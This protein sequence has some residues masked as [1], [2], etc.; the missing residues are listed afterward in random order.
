[1]NRIMDW[2]G[3]VF[4]VAN[5]GVASEIPLP[6][7]T[8]HGEVVKWNGMAFGSNDSAQVVARLGSNVVDRCSLASG[9]YPSTNYRLTIPMSESPQS[10]KAQPG[11]TVTFEVYYDGTVHA[12]ID[13]AQ[14][15]VVGAPATFAVCN[16]VVGTDS[17]A[18]GLPD[19]YEA[20]LEPY[21][22][23]KG[24][25][26]DEITSSDDFD[27]DGFSNLQEFLAGTV[28][29]MGEDFPSI[30]K[31][32]PLPAGWFAFTFMTAPGR[33]YTVQGADPHEMLEWSA[34][35]FSRVA[36]RTPDE[37]FLSTQDDGVVTLY[38]C[39]TNQA[40]L[41]QLQID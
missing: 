5:V 29:V 37:T 30:Q 28:P 7:F 36:D 33:T 27:G 38:L 35:I 15:P 19:E 31:W 22:L 2:I 18:N 41:Y 13:D 32:T 9:L 40:Q 26:L 8:Y 14:L 39:P 4:L 25:A 24:R 11:D 10:G 12:V 21:Y 20:L 34:E 17:N 3:L 6:P 1:M 23:M 16:M